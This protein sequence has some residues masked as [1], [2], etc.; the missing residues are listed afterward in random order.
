MISNSDK[1]DK[2]KK[3]MIFIGSSLFRNGAYKNNSNIRET[4]IKYFKKIEELYPKSEYN[5]LFKLR[6]YY[7]P[8][9]SIDYIKTLLGKED[10]S[11]YIVLNPSIS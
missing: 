10:I 4:G 1:Y 2:N 5:Y 7:K 9:N 8:E 6:P 3:N 11:D